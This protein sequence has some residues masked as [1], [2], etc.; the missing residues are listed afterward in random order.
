MARGEEHSSRSMK[1]Q[2]E[3]RWSSDRETSPPPA[4]ASPIEDQSAVAL[5]ILKEISTRWDPSRPPPTRTGL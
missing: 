3:H 2:P 4:P 1:E 5:A